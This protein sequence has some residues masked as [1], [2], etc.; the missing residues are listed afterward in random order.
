[1][2]SS[3]E[4]IKEFGILSYI[5]LVYRIILSFVI[6]LIFINFSLAQI[7][8]DTTNNTISPSMDNVDDNR[9]FEPPQFVIPIISA[10]IGFIIGGVLTFLTTLKSLRIQARIS[11]ISTILK[12]NGYENNLGRFIQKINID[13]KTEELVTE[14]KDETGKIWFFLL[15]S[16][17]RNSYGKLKKQIGEEDWNG[18]IDTISDFLGGK[19]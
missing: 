2:R 9:D 8:N 6:I 17:A 16:P 15:F 11:Y 12:N 10:S 7:A 14:L 1:M 19:W 18:S 3:M 5:N 4:M 13:N